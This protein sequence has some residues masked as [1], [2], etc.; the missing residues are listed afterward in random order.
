MDATTSPGLSERWAGI[1]A[2]GEVGLLAVQLWM[3]ELPFTRPVATSRSTHRR[4]PLVLVRVIGNHGRE[5]VEGWGECAALADTTYDTE[6]ARRS[7]ALLRHAL[8]PGLIDL[9]PRAGRRVPRPSELGGIRRAAPDATLAFAALEMAVADLHLRVSGQSLA[10][11]LGVAGRSVPVGAVL[12]RA[13]STEALVAEVAALVAQG[14]ARVKLKVGPGWDLEPVAAVRGAFPDLAIQADAN[15]AYRPTD[16]DHL[17]GLDRFGLLCIEQ[18][19]D[20]T[21]LEGH[22]R[23]AGRM[24][25]PVCLDES[26]DSPR[27]VRQA[28]AMGA[29]SVVYIKPAR[30]GGLGAALEV[31]ET[32]SAEGVPLWMGGMYESGYAR[33]VNATFAALPGFAWPGDL[34]PSRTYLDAD[35]VPPPALRRD[36]TDGALTVEVPDGPGLGPPPDLD[37]LEAYEITRCWLEVPRG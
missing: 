35:L 19:L 25:T 11:F 21:D 2:A 28:L 22:A 29:C 18:P 33:G 23:L 27:S 26:L 31:V 32:C 34:Q 3:V 24:A 37:R 9:A 13:E 14:I 15:G 6:D 1:G 12:G 10:G 30:L 4:R 5:P 8:V 36:G 17:V 20:P 7:F 16:A